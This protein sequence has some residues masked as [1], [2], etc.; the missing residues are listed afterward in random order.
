MPFCDASNEAWWWTRVDNFQHGHLFSDSVLIDK[1]LYV[2]SNLYAHQLVAHCIDTVDLD[3]EKLT[4]RTAEF[5]DIVIRGRVEMLMSNAT[6]VTSMS[7]GTFCNDLT[8]GR[9]LAVGC[10]A[11]I[12]GTLRV[13]GGLEVLG[14]TTLSNTLS[15]NSNGTF[16]S[17]VQ[18]G[19]SL[20]VNGPTTLSNTLF[21][22]SN[23]SFAS[24]VQVGG[25]LQVNGPTTLSN[26]LFVNS[27]GSFASSVQVGGSLQVNGPTTLSNTLF[28]N[29]NLYVGSNA[30][31]L[32]ESNDLIF[33]SSNGYALRITQPAVVQDLTVL[34][35]LSLC[36]YAYMP[37][38]DASNEAWWWTRVDNF[39]HGHLFS[40]SVLIDKDL[41]VSSNLYAHQVV[42]HCIDTVDLDV[43]KLTAR[44]AEFENVVIRGDLEIASDVISV[45]AQMS[46]LSNISVAGQGQFD[47]VV[48]YDNYQWIGF[49]SNSQS[50]VYWSADLDMHNTRESA[51]LI[52]RSRNGTMVTFTDDFQ[53]GLL[54][55]TGRHRLM[56]ENSNTVIKPDVG[57]VVVSTGKYCDLNGYEVI[58]IDEALP[59]VSLAQRAMDSR[60][61]GVLGGLNCDARTFEIGNM[62]F[63]RC[64]FGDRDKDKDMSRAIVQSSG[65]GC[66]WVCDAN[67][68]ISNGD[69]LCTSDVPGY[70]MRQG[71]ECFMNYTIAKATCDCIFGSRMKKPLKKKTLTMNGK[72]YTCILIGCMYMC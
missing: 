18:V 24:S 23:G 33:A 29:Q 59:V 63:L 13:R 61:V 52:F 32:N 53:S 12:G 64:M 65:E 17:S 22:N 62:R 40:D 8:T 21:V 60:A 66:I 14:P 51:D 70:A 37:F 35:R 54:N 38:C 2:S 49:G 71:T 26:T 11:E 50:N 48:V 69:F 46:Y 67:G 6:V 58:T 3:V 16:A 30:K 4:A 39:Q 41:Y 57:H 1:D 20:Q 47:S 27:N 34:G 68:D 28:L 43:E 7:D 5:E 25:S 36:N 15:V 42:A 44:T 10:N 56:F 9:N 72:K 45:A 31:I 55:F 19:G